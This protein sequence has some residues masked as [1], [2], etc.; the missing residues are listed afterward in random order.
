[1][2]SPGFWYPDTPSSRTAKAQQALLAP[3]AF[4]YASAAHLRQHMTAPERIS[5]PVI[6]IGNF[7]AG[8]AGKTPVAIAVCERLKALGEQPHFLSR[9]YGGS[10]T[11]PLQVDPADHTAARVG[12]EPLLLAAHAPAWVARDRVSGALE[13]EQ[14]GA[15]V[16]VLDDGF[17]NP[18]LYK[19][20]SLIVVDT[21]AGIG[22]GKVIPAGPLREPLHRAL[23]RATALV[24]LGEGALS[25][26]L[27]EAIGRQARP[28]FRAH[29]KPDPAA[30]GDIPGQALVAYAGIGRPEK[31][32][33]TLRSMGADITG[34]RAFADHHAFSER[35]A[36]A[37]LQLAQDRHA[38]LIT[39]QKDA[40]R[41][42]ALRGPAGKRLK[43]ES[44]ILPVSACFEDF[45]ALDAL[46]HTHLTAARASHTYAPPGTRST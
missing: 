11:G 12:D 41:L 32:F 27:A 30:S 18:R 45:S 8:G 19:D 3:A 24:A 43:E 39:T 38:K 33:A 9:G 28:L 36:E 16:I 34:I 20:M 14:A 42:K 46:L 22:N 23:E 31:F 6:C 2:R 10:E 4:I 40:M 1:M 37:L 17:Q 35:D 26:S 25:G 7:T 21:G 13:A 5:V 44:L 29:L 15:S